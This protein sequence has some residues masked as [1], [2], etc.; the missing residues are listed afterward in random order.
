MG[1]GLGVAHLL[2]RHRC[3][4]HS[5]GVHIT[6]PRPTRSSVPASDCAVHVHCVVAA[7]P[8]ELHSTSASGPL[9]VPGSAGQLTHRVALTQQEI[10]AGG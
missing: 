5:S 4:A 3:R 6:V 10:G 8:L 9:L 1:W 7:N 2:N